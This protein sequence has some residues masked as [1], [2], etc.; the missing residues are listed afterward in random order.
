MNLKAAYRP[1]R[2]EFLHP[3]RTAHGE[4]KVREGFLVR[5]E[6]ENGVGY[7]EIAPIPDFGTETIERAANFLE[8]WAADPIIMPSGLPCSN[9]AL[10]SAMQQLKQPAGPAVRD[11]AVA[12]L[13]PAGA[14][15]LGAAK[16]KLAAGY[17]VLKWK[18][19]VH[20]FEAEKEILT[21]LLALLPKEAALRLDANGGLDR[22]GVASWLELLSPRA[23]Q[24]EYLE[25]PL[26]PGEE[27]VMEELARESGIAIALDESLNMPDRERWLT[28]DAWHGPLVI[29]P[30]L[31]GNI[32]LLCEQLRPLAAQLVFSSVFET[33]IGLG[34]ALNLADALPAAK[35]AIGFD[36]RSAF[37]DDL[38]GFAASPRI[39]AA[40]RDE[41]NLEAI[42]NQ[43]PPSK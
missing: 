3:L 20:T 10:T 23:S 29:K 38:A 42:W 6:S 26:A 17:T 5:L 34:L 2:R 22:K 16:E 31:M 41:I 21:E 7:G 8:Q 24:I 32:T 39:L 40:D 25:Q 4:W 36:T 18:I 14:D 28:P 12:G 35:H 13:L 43:L 27:A 15:A 37:G 1:Y 11:Y 30:L 19:G 9:F 33:G